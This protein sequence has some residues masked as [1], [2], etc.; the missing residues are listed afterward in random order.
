MKPYRPT[1]LPFL[2]SHL[3]L[4]F[5]LAKFTSALCRS[6]RQRLTVNSNV[7]ALRDWMLFSSPTWSYIVCLPCV[8]SI[9]LLLNDSFPFPE[10]LTS[11]NIHIN[12]FCLRRFTPWSR[13]SYSQNLVQRGFTANTLS[14]CPLVIHGGQGGPMFTVRLGGP[15][16]A[17]VSLLPRRHDGF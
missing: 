2:L 7:P 8:D 10:L 15:K 11:S 3:L 12:T 13:N 17:D 14:C 1:F 5:T 6:C 16:V 4:L 9:I